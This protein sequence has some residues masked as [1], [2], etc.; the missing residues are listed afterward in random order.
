MSKKNLNPD[1][2]EL[3]LKVVRKLHEWY[4]QLKIEETAT[5]Y[6]E[7]TTMKR[8]VGEGID[9]FLALLKWQNEN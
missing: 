8:K 2:D 5:A 3:I 6:R 9:K 1:D 4:G 7:V